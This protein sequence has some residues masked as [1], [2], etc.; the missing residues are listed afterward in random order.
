[1]GICWGVGVLVLILGMVVGSVGYYM[2]KWNKTLD[3][4]KSGVIGVSTLT[5]WVAVMMILI[6]IQ[7]RY[8]HKKI[9]AVSSKLD[10]VLKTGVGNN[11][12]TCD[13]EFKTA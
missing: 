8:V 2:V 1:M 9:E 11:K 4:R 7:M 6:W 12:E 13:E 10:M 5:I 3:S